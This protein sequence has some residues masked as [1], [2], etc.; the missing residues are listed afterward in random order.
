MI[1]VYRKSCL[2]PGLC[3]LAV[4]AAGLPPAAAAPT[5]PPQPVDRIVA[6]VG[7]ETILMS[8]VNEQLAILQANQ[9]IDMSDTAQVAEAR[10]QILNQMIDEK[11]VF[12]YASQQGIVVADDQINA[13]VEETIR[14]VRDRLGSQAALDAELEKQGMT[15]D[16][17]RDRYRQD[18]RR[19]MMSQRI[20]DREIRSKVKVTDADVDTFFRN[21]Q[22]QLP[23]KPDQFHLAHIH[24]APKADASRRAAARMR[25][26]EV[27]RQLEAGGNWDELA[28]KYSEDPTT[29]RNGGDLGEVEEGDFDPAFEAAVHPLQPGQRSGIVETSFGYHII[30][31]VGRTG[32]RYHARHILI[33]AKPT[34][35]DEAAA[36]Q[37]AQKAHDQAV[38]GEAWNILVNSYSDDVRTKDNGGDLGMVPVT[39]LSREYVEALDS[40]KVGGVSVVLQGPTGYHVF[41]LLG[42]EASGPY[43]LEE[44]RSQLTNMLTQ[45]KLSEEYD[46]WIAGIR[47][48]AYVEIKGL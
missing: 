38:K 48:K 45:R 29:A 34:P 11:L 2:L 17:L 26:A 4:M 21:N 47:K 40:L 20:V 46:R 42:R 44:I 19:Q 27:L 22:A 5:S 9:Q 15:L 8:E 41:K 25:A 43:R 13:Q 23:L 36:I 33:Q 32:T 37:R 10:R 31:L 30:Q 14:N 1:T 6:V 39:Q 28:A 3:L 24:V 35:G 18:I 7:D 12:G 16:G